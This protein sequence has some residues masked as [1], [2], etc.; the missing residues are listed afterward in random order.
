MASAADVAVQLGGAGAGELLADLARGQGLSVDDLAARL[1]AHP[2]TAALQLHDVVGLV[3]KIGKSRGMRGKQKAAL[4]LEVFALLCGKIRARLS[5]PR[6]IELVTHAEEMAPTLV[7]LAVRPGK[8]NLAEIVR[9]T[10][11]IERAVGC[12]VTWCA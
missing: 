6:Q 9:E 11:I 3:Q 5:D 4:A 10:R 8:A 2:A 1:A 12:C 7:E